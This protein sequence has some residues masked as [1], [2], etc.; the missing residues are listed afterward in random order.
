MKENYVVCQCEQVKY[1]DVVKAL[2]EQKKFS[3]VLAAFDRV[4]A[5]TY[6]SSGCGKCYDKVLDL[7][8]DI[9]MGNEKAF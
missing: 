1:A 3:D 7:I 9:L 6:C 4:K 2:Q 5:V 8:S